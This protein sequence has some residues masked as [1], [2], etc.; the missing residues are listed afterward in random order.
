MKTAGML[1]ISVYFR[2]MMKS[3]AISS[4]HRKGEGN[5]VCEAVRCSMWYR[6]WKYRHDRQALRNV[7]LQCYWWLQEGMQRHTLVFFLLNDV[8]K[9]M[10]CAFI[11]FWVYQVIYPYQYHLILR[12]FILKK[13]MSIGECYIHIVVFLYW[14]Y[15]QYKWSLNLPA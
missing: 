7:F 2:L 9:M 12:I 15:F 11:C 3:F 6:I 4:P 8:K 1:I 10:V 5:I 13:V 14:K